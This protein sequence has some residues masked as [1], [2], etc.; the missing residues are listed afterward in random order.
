VNRVGVVTGMV[1]EARCLPRTDAGGVLTF[2]CSGGD[3]GRAAECARRLI[4]EGADGLLSFGLAGGLDPELRVGAVV[5]GEGVIGPDGKRWL[6]DR[7]WC[8][9][10]LAEPGSAPLIVGDVAG[11][12]RALVSASEKAELF[13]A[14][15][16]LTVDMESH[17]VA[18]V[19]A[20]NNVPFAVLR[21]VADT[22]ARTLPNAALPG[23]GTDGRARPA[24]VLGQ[25]VWRPWEAPAVFFL[26][27][28]AAKALRS[29]RRVAATSS[30]PLLR[31]GPA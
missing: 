18:R 19:A 30:A 29:L 2:L 22:A 28:V 21:A 14:T 3:S 27:L 8:E 12:D 25:L 24:A 11:S 15:R 9:A 23:I 6:A 1:A 17:A 13:A 7:P 31:G 5:L 4:A 10:F 26:A 20:E 16:A